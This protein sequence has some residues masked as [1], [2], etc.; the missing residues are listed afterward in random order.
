MLE[1]EWFHVHC[2]G[3]FINLIILSTNSELITEN[4]TAGASSVYLHHMPQNAFSNNSKYWANV[5]YQFPAMIWTNYTKSY[6]L[7]KIGFR[8]Q[9]LSNTPKNLSVIG[10]RNCKNW[11]TLFVIEDGNFT[12]SN[13]YR[14]WI[15]PAKDRRSF[16]C[17]GLEGL[18]AQGAPSNGHMVVAHIIMWAEMDNTKGKFEF[19]LCVKKVYSHV[20]TC[21]YVCPCLL[22]WALQGSRS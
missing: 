17:I 22:G 21:S 4:G 8:N 12:R 13:E 6:R 1:L 18:A 9:A 11:T 20:Y 7:A 16:S 19:K 2:C 15:I 3:S 10:S 5:R 14:E